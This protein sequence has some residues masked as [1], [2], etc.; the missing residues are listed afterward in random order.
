M[1]LFRKQFIL[2]HIFNVLISLI[3]ALTAYHYA[4][5]Y[6]KDTKIIPQ[7]YQSYATPYIM[8]YCGQGFVLP[9]I[10]NKELINFLDQKADSITCETALRNSGGIVPRNEYVSNEYPVSIGSMYLGE[11]IVLLWKFEGKISW[12][13]TAKLGLLLFA[14]T[15]VASYWFFILFFHQLMALLGSLL[16]MSSTMHLSNFPHLRDYGKAPFFVTSFLLLVYIYKN[17]DDYGK[18]I[19]LTIILGIVSGVGYG[20]RVD[21][22]IFLPAAYLIFL[23]S[24]LQLINF[25]TNDLKVI[26]KTIAKWISLCLIM[27]LVFKLITLPITSKINFDGKDFSPK[28]PLYHVTLLGLTPLDTDTNKEILIENG[29]LELLASYNDIY[30]AAKIDSS[31]LHHYKKETKFLN[32]SYAKSAFDFLIAVLVNFPDTLLKRGIKSAFTII[33]LPY[34]SANRFLPTSSRLV[35]EANAYAI[36]FF[37]IVKNINPI[38]IFSIAG[39]LVSIFYSQQILV[40]SIFSY[41]FFLSYPAIQFNIRHYFQMEILAILT[42]LFIIRE[43]LYRVFLLPTFIRKRTFFENFSKFKLKEALTSFSIFSMVVAIVLIPL[44]QYQ[45]NKLKSLVEENFLKAK[46]EKLKAVVLTNNLDTTLNLNL[47]FSQNF[48]YIVVEFKNTHSCST[49]MS[50]LKINYKEPEK[51]FERSPEINFAKLSKIYYPVYPNNFLGL[52]IN[53]KVAHCI[54]NIS[55]INTIDYNLKFQPYIFINRA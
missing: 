8:A 23:I 54:D 6:Q 44:K 26:L 46:T 18:S 55:R 35:H 17:K 4:S 49:G 12:T 30:L 31:S 32:D 2:T 50:K 33:K 25:K 42:L 19:W 53:S 15:I 13:S 7:W 29:Y 52:K 51:Y 27:T 11:A 9:K 48:E 3:L 43:V 10:K 38:I 16:F 47:K 24:H 36:K 28:A 37:T 39:L 5:L 34:E 45:H 40:I 41:I 14:A 21:L 22:A 20:F 1:T